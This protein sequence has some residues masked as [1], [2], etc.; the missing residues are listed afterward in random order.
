MRKLAYLF[1][2]TVVVPACHGKSSLSGTSAVDVKDFIAAFKPLSLPY[3]ASDSNFTHMADTTTISYQVFTQFIPDSV[4]QKDFGKTATRIKVRP[5]GKFEKDNHMFLLATIF[6]DKK[7]R[8]FV[9]VFSKENKY[10]SHLGL[11][12]QKA[13]ED[14][15]N[16]NLLVT[17][18]PTFILS[19]ERVNTQ[20][21]FQYT[22]YGYAF[23]NVAGRFITV[24]TDTNEGQKREEIFNPIDTLPAKFRLSADYINDKKNFI[25]VRDADAPNKYVFFIHFEKEDNCTGEL[26]G[27]IS[28]R[29]ATHGYYHIAGNPCVINFTFSS[30][31]VTVKEDGNCG[32]HR[33]IKCFFDDTYRKRKETKKH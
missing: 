11:L 16:H 13:R 8:L 5:I 10:V 17:S 14:N 3:H 32:S 22:R 4:L 1:F 15:Y 18:E 26:K 33:G 19:R 2:I 21:Q 6:Y 31:S 30:K 28:M 29:D 27:D 12:N 23:N 9:F 24:L 20:N 25:S 7:A